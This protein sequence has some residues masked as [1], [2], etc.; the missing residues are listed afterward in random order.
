MIRALKREDIPSWRKLRQTLWPQILDS[1]NERETEEMF[2]RRDRFA[3]FVYEEQNGLI[4]F[5][6]VNLRDYAEGC[7]TTPVGYIEGWYV[8]PEFR[9]RGVGRQL[10]AAGEDW[11]RSEGCTEMASDSELA[12]VDSQH[13]HARLGYEEA[14]RIVCFRKDLN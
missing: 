13:A 8:A 6:E 2:S 1:E 5:I 10:I 4:G 12:N 14:E 3:V 7:E 11:A 9:L